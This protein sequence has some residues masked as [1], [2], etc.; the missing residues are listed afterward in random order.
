[1]QTG[2]FLFSNFSSGLGWG[3]GHMRIRKDMWKLSTRQSW[4]SKAKTKHS[5]YVLN[6]I[7]MGILPSCMSVHYACLVPGDQK[8]PSNPWDQRCLLV[9]MWVLREEPALFTTEPSVNPKLHSWIERIQD[10]IKSFWSSYSLTPLSYPH[11]LKTRVFNRSD[12]ALQWQHL[13][14]A[15]SGRAG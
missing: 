2:N 6:F 14:L 7:C 1:M 13:Y 12:F 9:T 3:Q 5:A 4:E 8:R 10:T 11:L 15:T